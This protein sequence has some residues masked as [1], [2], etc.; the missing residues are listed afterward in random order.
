[1]FRAKTELVGGEKV[2]GFK[3][4]IKAFMDNFFQDFGKGT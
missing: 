1:M 4:G 2:I 3:V